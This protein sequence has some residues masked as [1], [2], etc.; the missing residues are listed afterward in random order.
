VP[1]FLRVTLAIFA[2]MAAL[3]GALAVFTAIGVDEIERAHPPSGRFVEVEGGRLHL[4]ELGPT[5]APPVE[6]S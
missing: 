3:L 5:D 6:A 2:M 1:G 4:V